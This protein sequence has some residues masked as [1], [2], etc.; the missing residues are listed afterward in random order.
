MNLRGITL[1]EKSPSPKVTGCTIPF[2]EHFGNSEILYMED[3]FVAARGWARAE[4]RR[5]KVVIRGPEKSLW[6]WDS[7]E[8]G[9][10]SLNKIKLY[11]M[12][13]TV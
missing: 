9:D 11:R 13:T 8:S 12:D 10:R 4:G 7:P 6:G 5:V 3:R 2:I 1:S